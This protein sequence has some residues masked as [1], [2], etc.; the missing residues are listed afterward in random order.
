MHKRC[1]RKDSQQP[2]CTELKTGKLRNDRWTHWN[3]HKEL[4]LI[5]VPFSLEMWSYHGEW[6]ISFAIDFH[7]IYFEQ[8]KNILSS[9]YFQR[10]FE[11]Q[12]E[13]ND[14]R[15]LS[16][17]KGE[18]WQEIWWANSMLANVFSYSHNGGS[19]METAILISHK[20][21]TS[22]FRFVYYHYY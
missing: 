14:G 3:R 20:L 7:S 19:K 11:A 15:I 18:I 6:S 16:I 13:A 4:S 12:S 21:K 8:N 9:L 1:A 10:Y 2:S 22:L 17:V 5:I